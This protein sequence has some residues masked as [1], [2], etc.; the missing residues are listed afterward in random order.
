MKE[1]KGR[2]EGRKGGI[3]R[4]AEKHL[5]CKPLESKVSSQV[6]SVLLSKVDFTWATCHPNFEMASVEACLFPGHRF[7]QGDRWPETGNRRMEEA[8]SHKTQ[9]S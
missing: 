6:N 5:P 7:G 1:R 8:T 4:K 2:K 3:E 9:V